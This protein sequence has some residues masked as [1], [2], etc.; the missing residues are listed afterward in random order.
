[1]LDRLTLTTMASSR[2][3]HEVLDFVG[4]GWAHAFRGAAIR[5][6]A[7]PKSP[8]RIVRDLTPANRPARET[9]RWRA[10]A[11]A[12]MTGFLLPR[13]LRGALAVAR[14]EGASRHLDRGRRLPRRRRG[15]SFA[16]RPVA[17]PGCAAA[18]FGIAPASPSLP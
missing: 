9:S 15:F 3:T 5:R 8:R 1:M 11:E 10:A 4:P 7:L 16:R 17:A 6:R 12:R 13:A 18:C 2:M 14:G